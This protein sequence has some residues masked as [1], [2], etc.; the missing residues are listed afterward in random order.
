MFETRM[1]KF[2]DDVMQRGLQ[3]GRQEGIK[4]GLKERQEALRRTLS[5]MLE[6]RFGAGGAQLKDKIATLEDTE[7]LERLFVTFAG[8]PD[9]ATFLRSFD[10][11][12]PTGQAGVSDDC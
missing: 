4:E 3:D 11:Q 5:A 12:P 6:V 10:L 7:V 1:Q 8:S 9:L 2:E